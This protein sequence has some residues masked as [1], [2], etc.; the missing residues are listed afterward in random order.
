VIL[1]AIPALAAAA[2]Y[3]LA[4]IAAARWKATHPAR[5]SH[6]LPPLSILKPI[7][8]R[9]PRF[10][11]AIFSHAAQDYPEFEI[12]FGLADADDPA[13]EDIHRLR[14][15]FPNRRIE[16]VI[17][18]TEA[19]NAKVGVL[20]ELARRARYGLLLVNDSDIV[21]DPGYLRTVT[22]PLEDPQVGLV[23]CLY[24]AQAESFASS[25]EALGIATEFAPSV[26]VARLLG[27][28]EFALGSTM[29]FRAAALEKFGG[30]DAIAD[31]IADDYHLGRHICEL[32]Y[33]IEFA[34]MVVE[35]DLGGESWLQ[36]W[37][38]QLRWSRTIRV[39]RPSGYFGYVITHA[40]LWSAVSVVAGQWWA[41]A[42][43]MS[44]RMIAGIWIGAGILRDR[45]VIRNAWMIPLRDLFGF[46]VWTAGLAG[47]TVYWR[48]RIL[49]LQPD[50]RIQL[51]A[52]SRGDDQ[53]AAAA[54]EGR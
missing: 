37:R 21:V 31:Y 2:Y 11:E 36:T 50:G 26:M 53:R 23:T 35:T 30:F 46:A 24:R 7:H 25:A 49:T 38:H 15:E 13:L 6:S 32:G 10:Y 51:G 4:T 14:R 17:A 22:A 34:P 42:I 20:A 19:P 8:G 54:Y 16:I 9:D 40:T 3:L 33:R 43:A 12:L 52:H 47:H 48:D 27:V 45:E 28:A 39:S 41:A 1:L 5:A 18:P 29:V 44:L